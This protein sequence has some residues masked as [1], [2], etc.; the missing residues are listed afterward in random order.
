[1]IIMNIGVDNLYAFKKF[2]MNMSYPKKVVNTPVE[3]EYLKSRPNFRYRKVNILMG[4]NATGKTT[5]GELLMGF[6]NFLRDGNAYRFADHI[7]DERKWAHLCVDF[8]AWDNRLYRFTLKTKIN[9]EDDKVEKICDKKLEFVS[10][11]QNDNYE[12][13]AKRL[14]EGEGEEIDYKDIPVPGWCFQYGHR[15][16]DSIKSIE[17]KEYIKVLGLI[18]K[19]LDP[20]VKSVHKVMDVENTYL[21]KLNNHSVLIQD[22][23]V[24]GEKI[25]SSGTKMGFK[26]AYSIASMICGMHNFYYCDELFTYVNSDIEIACLSL[27][28]EKL[29]ERGQLFFTTHNSDV[30]EMDL[31]N[32]SFCFLKKDK[33]GANKIEYVNAS[34][35][36]KKNTDSIRNALDNDVFSTSPNVEKIYDIADIAK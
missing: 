32:H 11:N 20:A 28:I 12:T 3:G 36:L 25:F 14:D 34:D 13:C 29:S 21:I 1:M 30:A 18:M 4:S 19:T 26:I 10:I 2:Y 15:I 5:L 16:V 8:V 7:T 24:K 6:A 17:E 31:P 22:G 27:M 33:D 35:Y 9:K 23:D